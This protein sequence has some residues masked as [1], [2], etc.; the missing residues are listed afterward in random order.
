MWEEKFLARAK[1]KG[2]K[3]VLLGKEVAPKDSVVIDNSTS[4]GKEAM[5]KRDANKLAF[6]ELILSI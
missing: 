2:Y 1:R 6:E 5:R 4:A 3:N